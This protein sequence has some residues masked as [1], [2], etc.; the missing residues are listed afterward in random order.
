MDKSAKESIIL[1][2]Q[3]LVNLLG[4]HEQSQEFME[5][6]HTLGHPSSK[7]NVMRSTLYEFH[8]HGVGMS[9]NT[10][11]GVVYLISFELDDSPTKNGAMKPYSG[12]LF[13][14]IVVTDSPAAVETK[15]SVK[16]KRTSMSKKDG[17]IGSTY[18]IANGEIRCE[19]RTENGPL[20]AMSVQRP[21]QSPMPS[22]S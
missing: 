1:I 2:G 21:D 22:F 20:Y 4:K 16:P 3:K 10:Q 19:F 12:D 17:S 14:G 11:T 18:P 15:L 9:V 6:M 5:V 7:T 13:G 8:E